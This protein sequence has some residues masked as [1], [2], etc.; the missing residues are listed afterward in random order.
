MVMG[1]GGTGKPAV[2]HA[3]KREFVR[4]GLGRLLVTAYTGVAAA[5]FGGPTLLSLLGLSLEAKAAVRVRTAGAVEREARRA[6]F[7]EECGAPIEEFGGVV[8]DEISFVDAST[9]GHVDA[10]FGNLLGCEKENGLVCGGMPML[11]AGDNFQKPPPGGAPWHKLMVAVA[12]EEVENPLTSGSTFAKQRGL[13][14]LRGAR[15]VQLTRLM[16]ARDDELFIAYQQQMRT[17]MP[18]PVPDAFLKALRMVSRADLEA[19]AAWRF[20]PIGVLAVVERDA[21]NLAQLKAFAEAFNLPIVRWRLELV[22]D[23]FESPSVREQ[24][25]EHEPNLWGYFVEGAPVHLTTTIKSVRKLV[26]GSPAL[27]D[28]L[29]VGNNA[30]RRL[31]ADAYEE[32]FSEHTLEAAPLA[33][34]VVVGGTAA[35]P[36]LWHEVPLD[37][38]SGLIPARAD[39]AQVIPLLKTPKI[40]VVNCYSVFTAQQGIAKDVRVKHHQYGLAFALTDFKLQGRTLPKL[41]ISVCKRHRLPWMTLDAF[42]VL[43]SR[44]KARAAL[45]LL[46]HDRAGL[47]EVAAQMPNEY[48]HA[49][50]NGY[51]ADGEWSDERAAAAL[52]NTRSARLREQQ[53]AAA[54]K[55]AAKKAAPKQ[56]RARGKRPLQPVAPGETNARQ[57]PTCRICL[58]RGHTARECQVRVVRAEA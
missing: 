51:T 15:R 58:R 30:D 32:G 52:S 10:S 22:D 57:P 27:L 45:R 49:W 26:N 18:H 2:V 16:R 4:L 28:S 9:F 19:D 40:E 7:K 5:P 11:L 50:D 8:I 31:L 36:R 1:A 34:N 43:I 48:L 25:Y 6:K 38:L 39:G 41:I 56:A 24:L 12:A 44:V 13:R 20:A 42:Y 55:R 35:S 47:E 53:A 21:I 46:Q 54:A 33:V 14:L 17:D 3:L 23:A 37:D 29:N